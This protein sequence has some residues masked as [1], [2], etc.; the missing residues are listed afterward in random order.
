MKPKEILALEDDSLWYKDAVIY[1]LHVKAFADSTGDGIGDFPGLT[2]KL[3][4]LQD[5]GV[6]AIWLLPF[7]QSP[8]KDD[9][10]DIS[11]Y[12]DIHP[13][14]GTLK[15]FKI[16]LK[17]AHRRGMRVITELVVNHTSDQHPWFQLARKAKPG[18]PKRDFYVWSETSDL[19]REA[20]IIFKDFESSNWSWDPVAK[21]YFWHRF[22]SHQP[23]LN[24]D[25][26]LVQKS[27]LR[28]IDFWFGLG[29]DG[30]RL[31]A[32][33]YLYE[34]EGTNCENLPETYAFLRK[35]RDHV[36]SRFKNRMLLA[37]ANQWP[38]DAV[39]YFGEGDECHMAFHFPSMP[40]MFMALHMED[41]FPIID[42]LEQ[43][44]PIP[45]NCQ[46]ALFLRN[47]D[48]LTLEMVTDE[49]RDYMYRVYAQNPRMRI[50]LGIR[51]R[52]APLL[53]NHRRRIELMNGLLFSMPGTPIIYY[54]DEIGMGDNIY[55]GD[56]NGVRTP[57]QW[58]ADRNAGF[59]RANPQRLFL[60]IIIDPE[61]HY[62][63]IN[64]EA[65]QSNPYSLLWWMKRLIA[66][67]KRYK[68]FGRGTIEF[69]QPEN[70]KVLIFIRRYQ[71]E[72]I[73]VVANLSRFVQ[74]LE[75]DLSTFR[76]WVPVEIFGRIDFPPIGE[77]PYFLTLGPHSFY[78]FS[79]EERKTLST[80]MTVQS[81]ISQ[82]PVLEVTGRWESVLQGQNRVALEKILPPYMREQRWFGG[83][84]EKIKGAMI[85]EV[86]PVQ[87]ETNPA[88]LTLVRVDYIGADTEIYSLPLTYASGKRAEAILRDHPQAV[89]V[90]LQFK[91]RREEG[92]V[93]DAVLEEGF[94]ES[95]LVGMARHRGR[96]GIE[97]DLVASR[98]REFRQLRG[99]GEE[100]LNVALMKAEQSNTSL[101]FG[102]RFILKLFRHL[103]AG[104]NPDLEIGRFLTGKKFNHIPPVAGAIEYHREKEEPITLAIL[105]GYVPNQGDAWKYTLDQLSHYFEHV[106]ASGKK[107]L[108]LPSS[109]ASPLNLI[110]QEFPPVV[111]EMIGHY[112]E[113]AR[114]LGQR[115][116]EMHVCLAS[117]PEDPGFA[118]EPFSRLY[119]R[120]LYQSMRNLTGQIFRLLRQ[121]IKDFPDAVRPDAQK[122]LNQE[123][124]ILERF[125]SIVDRKI[126]A[127]RIRCHGDYHLGQVLYTGKDFV[128]IDFEGEPARSLS[129]R[130]IKRSPLRDVSGMLR[131]FH[132]AAYAALLS[133]RDKGLIRP[134]DFSLL[135]ASA[136]FWRLWVSVVF[137]K[138]YV[139]IVSS[140]NFLPHTKEEFQALLDVFLLEKAIYELGYELNN[141]PNWVMIPVQGIQQLLSA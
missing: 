37:E 138:S 6:T 128:I 42:I 136:Q 66:L 52:L 61:Y 46:W 91:D 76:G 77:L 101:V 118:P 130:K 103:Q 59:S 17:E 104:V 45:E 112:L 35:L 43:T 11:S 24:Y 92:I 123:S 75:L 47:H 48:E 126:T 12:V 102:E 113:S 80:E 28:V 22:Y 86:L 78:W 44:P 27:I 107:A 14:Y 135:E 64:V 72:C 68:A 51:R 41:R 50:N 29:V 133:Q 125:Q 40:R 121:Q 134:E 99:A 3:D 57:M 84:A 129:E 31:D 10:Y 65:Q 62:E 127:M 109:A 116:G 73:L 131:S 97:G 23:D 30:L 90:R 105:H 122:V 49:E 58:S 88:F 95:L 2:Q 106:L 74:Y 71:E 18:S 1:E 124:R 56:R 55:L 114:L 82:L 108:A 110:E 39:A 21:A 117:A 5:L 137:L 19:Y 13:D 69:L 38:E 33:P 111:S 140:G 89:L 132:Y 94:A 93:Y 53:G 8:L 54:G 81:R 100:R 9:G 67:R 36:D 96:E 15:D 115:T 60:P 119:Q 139:H 7:C 87:D 26:P 141:R 98:T 79:L 83:K 63:P 4:Y 25:N 32:V 70:R 120:S 85:R 20:R 34:R 16:F